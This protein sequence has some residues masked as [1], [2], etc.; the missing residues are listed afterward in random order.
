[1]KA[2]TICRRVE[3][4]AKAQFPNAFWVRSSII[5]MPPHQDS[6]GIV[7]PVIFLDVVQNRYDAHSLTSQVR[8]LRLSEDEVIALAGELIAGLVLIKI[9]MQDPE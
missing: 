2:E 9:G 6:G 5:T 8:N 3:E 1:M 4:K 7:G